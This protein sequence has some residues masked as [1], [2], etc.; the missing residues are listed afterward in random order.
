[1]EHTFARLAAAV[2]PFHHLDFAQWFAFSAGL[3]PVAAGAL[4]VAGLA[5]AFAGAKHYPFRVASPL[6]GFLLGLALAPDVQALV[7]PLT[8]VSLRLV[9]YSLPTALGLLCGFFPMALPFTAVGV[10]GAAIGVAV[11]P[12]KEML[13]GLAPGF[14]VGGGIG[15]AAGRYVA[16]LLTAVSGGVLA[17]GGLLGILGGGAFGRTLTASP[18]GPVVVTLV[19]A[20]AGAALQFATY[21]NDDDRQLKKDQAREKKQLDKDQREREKRFATYR[22]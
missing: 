2:N 13:L 8:P 1:M 18:L 7:N 11:V 10:G 20:V 14:L 5:S 15:L 16:T 19:I 12:D 3:V 21:Q 6:F 9:S 4:L 22:R 17:T